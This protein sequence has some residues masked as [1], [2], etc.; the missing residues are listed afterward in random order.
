[1]AWSPPPDHS[2][3]IPSHHLPVS[4]R[5][6]S[7]RNQ[8]VNNVV[9][10]EGAILRSF[11]GTPGY[12]SHPQVNARKPGPALHPG[13]THNLLALPRDC[14][15]PLPDHVWSGG[16]GRGGGGGV[17]VAGLDWSRAG[18]TGRRFF[19]ARTGQLNRS[20]LGGECYR[21]GRGTHRAVMSLPLPVT[22]RMCMGAREAC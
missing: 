8:L 3:A 18:L 20:Q 13:Y 14:S 22:S 1:M 16:D 2:R 5:R 4:E 10:R 11:A 9:P 12:L 7:A 17:R 19:C 21:E 6:R 15:P